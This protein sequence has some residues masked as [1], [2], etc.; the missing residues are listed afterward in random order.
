MKDVHNGVSGG[1]FYKE[2]QLVNVRLRSMLDNILR[3]GSSKISIDGTILTLTEERAVSEKYIRKR[4]NFLLSQYPDLI[5][6]GDIIRR[7]D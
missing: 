6:D 7:K 1:S 4:F 5:I 3:G 2:Q